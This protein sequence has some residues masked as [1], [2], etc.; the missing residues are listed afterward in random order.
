ME[1]DPPDIGSWKEEAKALVVQGS[2]A[3]ALVLPRTHDS[4]TG[5]YGNLYSNLL[6]YVISAALMDDSLTNLPNPAGMFR[7][8]SLR[9]ELSRI[10]AEIEMTSRQSLDANTRGDQDELRALNLRVLDLRKTKEGLQAA[11]QR[12]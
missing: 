1:H 10:D 7:K 4:A 9:L 3:A 8:L 5:Q 2:W 12:P 11:L 6:D